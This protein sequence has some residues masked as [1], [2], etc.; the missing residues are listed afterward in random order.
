MIPHDKENKQCTHSRSSRF[1]NGR[2]FAEHHMRSQSLTPSIGIPARVREL[3]RLQ[4]WLVSE[5]VVRS[6]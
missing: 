1:I 2:S 6:M 5:T 3:L 4:L